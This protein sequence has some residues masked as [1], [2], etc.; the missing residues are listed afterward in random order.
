MIFILFCPVNKTGWELEELY[1]TLKWVFTVEFILTIYIKFKFKSLRCNI[2]ECSR[3]T[4]CVNITLKLLFPYPT[5]TVVFFGIKSS[6]FAILDYNLSLRL[7]AKSIKLFWHYYLFKILRLN[8]RQT[9]LRA[10]VA[11][12]IHY[13]ASRSKRNHKHLKVVENKFYYE[14]KSVK[15]TKT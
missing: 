12:F 3:P 11:Q 4:P 10:F 7:S 1:G 6:L 13:T 9:L 15:K 8:F 14:C 5:G 2:S